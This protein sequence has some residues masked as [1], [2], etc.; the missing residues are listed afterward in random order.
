MTGAK[1]AP[2]KKPVDD[3]AL[4][5]WVVDGLSL[6]EVVWRYY[7]SRPCHE[8]TGCNPGFGVMY[9]D[10]WFTGVGRMPGWRAGFDFLNRLPYIYT[11]FTEARTAYAGV[12]EERIAN[13]LAELEALRE[14]LR[15]LL[16]R[17]EPE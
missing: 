12:L 14:E 5:F 2:P 4:R 17:A 10:E 8:V 7:V 16:S 15:E 3:F 6:R 11:T 1:F 9:K 13:R